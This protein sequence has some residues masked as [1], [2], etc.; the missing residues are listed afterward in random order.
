[1]AISGGLFGSVALLPRR[2]FAGSV[3]K[4]NGKMYKLNV[5]L[6]YSAE[7]NGL[8]LFL[9]LSFLGISPMKMW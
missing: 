6:F 1:M 9:G 8:P 7:N 2:R 5:A 3:G 4:S